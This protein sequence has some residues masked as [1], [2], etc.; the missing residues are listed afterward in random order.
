MKI[1]FESV[2]YKAIAI[3]IISSCAINVSAKEDNFQGLHAK[4][5]IAGSNTNI[6]ANMTSSSFEFGG[7]SSIQN[8]S[9]F[10]CHNYKT[11]YSAGLEYWKNTNN[12]FMLGLEIND[13]F[14]QV[15][16]SR[17]SSLIAT[18]GVILTDNITMKLRN[19]LGFLAKAGYKCNQ[20][21]LA[22]ALVGPRIGWFNVASSVDYI[23]NTVSPSFSGNIVNE[24]RNSTKVG[25]SM[26]AG[27]EYYLGA[28]FIIGLEY[29]YTN[30]GNISVVNPVAPIIQSGTT[31]GSLTNTIYSFAATSSA[32]SLAISYKL[33]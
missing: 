3:G 18:S 13:A 10:K 5:E 14:P 32:I 19:S 8:T 29:V 16:V 33:F 23:N 11:I 30:Y 12:N 6:K 25:V 20:S 17:D 7:G 9:I 22:Y 1:F 26:G 31:I 2:C 24:G 27:V 28:K 4:V 15:K 21:T